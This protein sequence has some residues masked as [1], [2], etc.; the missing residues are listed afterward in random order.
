MTRIEREK[1]TVAKM[2]RIYCH[3][4]H[5]TPLGELCE[6]C[7]QI[8]DYAH[9]RLSHCRKGNSKGSCKKCET[10][11][12]A[13][14]QRMRIREIMRTVGPLMIFYHPVAAVRHLFSEFFGK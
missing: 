8:L 2:V 1:H 3:R 12:Y 11:C 9:T 14:E 10:H 5:R 7:E 6:E 13:P 4:T